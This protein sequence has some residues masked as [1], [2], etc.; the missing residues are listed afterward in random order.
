MA[1]PTPEQV[2]QI[3]QIIV[4]VLF[5][6]GRPISPL[7]LSKFVFGSTGTSKSVNGYLYSLASRG[8]T[9]KYTDQP[10][11]WTITAETVPYAQRIALPDIKE[12]PAKVKKAKPQAQPMMMPFGGQQNFA[13][14]QMPG[15]TT[16]NP[17]VT[18]QPQTNAF[19]PPP[20]PFNPPIVT[21]PRE[22]KIQEIVSL[23]R[24]LP[25]AAI[26]QLGQLLVAEINGQQTQVQPPPQQQFQQPIQ[27][28]VQQPAQQQQQ[29]EPSQQTQTQ[30]QMRPFGEIAS[31][32]F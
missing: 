18:Q 23:L 24:R 19:N 10:P 9:M 30:P 25:D 5:T 21:D 32:L 15:A 20:Q 26:D 27:T 28:Q 2:Q 4:N 7:Y 11:M 16:F 29:F 8:V 3:E 17:F 14:P 31:G 12:P 6:I 22:L 13:P 1:Q